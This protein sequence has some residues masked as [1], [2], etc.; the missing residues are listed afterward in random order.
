MDS[1]WQ[2]QRRPCDC[3]FLVDKDKKNNRL[4]N[5]LESMFRRMNKVAE[6]VWGV[7][8]YYYYTDIKYFFYS[9]GVFMHRNSYSID[10]SR[11]IVATVLQIL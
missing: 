2:F 4:E 5:Q 7:I 10:W 11:L 8:I 3:A 6:K 1:F 9:A